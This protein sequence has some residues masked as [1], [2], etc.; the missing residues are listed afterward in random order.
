MSEV[1]GPKLGLM[2]IGEEAKPPFAVLPDPRA[3]FA[4]RARRFRAL[5]PGHELGPYLEFLAKLCEA[6]RDI[7]ADLSPVRLP[8]RNAIGRA[9]EHG[10]PPI[11]RGIFKPDH[12]TAATLDRLLEC[13]AGSEVRG[14][15]AAAISAL[16]TAP[17]D[18]RR[19]HILTF[20]MRSKTPSPAT[21]PAAC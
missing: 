6:Q 8:A 12:V 3:V 13:L 18:E 17:A 15:T 9:L 10:M 2:N 1:G 20:L 21:S 11:A 7:Q 16:R 14:P 4:D 5:A 19:G